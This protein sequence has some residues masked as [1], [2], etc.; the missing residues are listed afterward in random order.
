MVECERGWRASYAYSREI[1]VPVPVRRSRLIPIAGL[2]RPARR[3]EKIA[4]ALADYGVPVD[5][6]ECASIDELAE[7]ASRPALDTEAA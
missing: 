2:R 7:I 4:D 1:F 6:V 5:L 3:P